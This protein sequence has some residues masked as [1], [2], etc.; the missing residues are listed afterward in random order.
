MNITVRGRLWQILW[1]PRRRLTSGIWPRM[2]DPIFRFWIV[3][4]IEIRR[5]F[6]FR[7]PRGADPTGEQT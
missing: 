5:F 1:W 2:S 6:I 3:G 7:T 4:P